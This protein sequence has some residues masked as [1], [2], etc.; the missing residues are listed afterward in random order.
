MTPPGPL[1]K[2]MKTPLALKSL[3]QDY[4]MDRSIG[5]I[6]LSL[7]KGMNG[8]GLEGKLWVATHPKRFFS[9]YLEPVLPLR[10]GNLLFRTRV[11]TK[12][13][14]AWTGKAFLGALREGDLAYLWPNVPYQVFRA[15]K[16]KGAL[17]AAEGINC[18]QAFA[19][20]IL[21]EEFSRL[22]LSPSSRITDEDIEDEKRKLALT[23]FLFAPS[24]M[25]AASFAGEGFPKE[26]ILQSSY[27]WEPSSLAG[28][29]R[30]LEP[31]R[32]LDVLF[33]GRIGVRKGAHFL[34]EAWEE[35]GIEG[36]LILAGRFFDDLGKKYAALLS[37]PD[38]VHLGFTKD[39]GSV[40]RSGRVLAF[41]SLE[42][43]SPL[44]TY[45]AMSQGLAMLVSPMAAGGVV[46]D[47]K[48]G[49]VLPPGDR[50]AWVEALRDLAAHPEKREALGRAARERAR[51]FTWDKVGARRR[52]ALLE[53]VRTLGPRG[54]GSP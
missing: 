2:A 44:V 33:V 8:P 16:D 53:A 7:V 49:L 47:G 43:G 23:D 28:E 3:F 31:S 52:E 54:K 24:P 18:H 29:G 40:Y 48:E 38:V 13:A 5:H 51:E 32:G 11:G 27:G 30:A 21:E 1:E 37:R 39:V 12:L 19:K 41:P 4:F 20:T 6:A 34:F 17:V 42:E 36:R 9:P 14:L 45:E 22:G 10:A 35:A 46:R 26:R 50:E 15:A 25:V